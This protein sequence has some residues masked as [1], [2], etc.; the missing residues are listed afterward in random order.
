MP[1]EE[2]PLE[3][4]HRVLDT[5]GLAQR[6]NLEYLKRPEIWLLWRRR[7]SWALPAAAA[8]ISIPLVL[9]IG[10]AKKAFSNGPVSR[11]HAIFGDRCENCHSQAF[12]SV[13]DAACL[14][15][16]DGPPHPAKVID[17]AALIDA[18]RCAQ[19]HIE[20]RGFS[21]LAEVRDANCTRCH[22]DLAH[23]GKGVR[24]KNVAITHFNLN[25]HPEFSPASRADLRPLH[26][27]HAAHMPS[28]PKTIN[29]M[30]LP[31]KCSDCHATD[32]ASDKGDLLPVTFDQNCRPCHSRELEF[33]VYQLLPGPMPAPHTKD[34]NT[35]HAFVMAAFQSG[36][37]QNP[38][39]IQKPLGRDT[40]PVRNP[41]AW[42]ERVVKDSEDFLFERKCSYCHEYEGQ[43][44]GYPMVRKVGRIRGQYV[45]GMPDGL[46]W[47]QRGEF[48][49]RAHRAVDCSSC[50]TTARTSTKTS[51]VLIPRMKSCTPC[52]GA[53]GTAIDNCAQCHLFHN[54]SKEMD[55]DRRPI[56]Q[57]ISRAPGPP[58]LPRLFDGDRF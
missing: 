18:P 38:A 15:C 49:H 26:L 50:H 11:A 58:L 53:S 55:K 10:G 6:L 48:S 42:L 47:L 39:I 20:H 21:R 51:D 33:D 56:D 46:P 2:K 17:M 9:G 14:K 3:Y 8:L 1:K 5:K 7:L 41:Q 30:K 57:L 29:G 35:I 54:K 37:Q 4:Q 40:E 52:H 13:P 31:M 19:C 45:E 27:N 23:H 22:S 43:N 44:G 34:V 36:L 25:G 24:I 12:S 16:H 32:P 28:S